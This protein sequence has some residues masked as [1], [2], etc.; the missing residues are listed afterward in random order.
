MLTKA[1]L[2][3]A[4]FVL[5]SGIAT[6]AAG[7]DPGLAKKGEQLYGAQKCQVCHAIQGKG[8][9]NNPLDGVGTKLTAAD[10]REWI[11]NPLEMTKKTKSTKKPPMPAKYKGLAPAEIDSLVAYMQ[12]LK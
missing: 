11:V 6:L 9:K 1:I 4:G 5:S 8:N 10:I 7:Q 12:S 2:L 3:A